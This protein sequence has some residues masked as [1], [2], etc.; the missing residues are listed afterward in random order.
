MTGS[1]RWA[2]CSCSL[3]VSVIT[4]VAA[5]AAAVT[6]CNAER[7]NALVLLFKQ[8]LWYLMVKSCSAVLVPS[9]QQAFHLLR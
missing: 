1:S 9:A 7:D 2:A 5:A 8:P 6:E 3:K 4:W